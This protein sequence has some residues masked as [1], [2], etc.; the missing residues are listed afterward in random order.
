MLTIFK[1]FFFNW[2]N[3][4]CRLAQPQ[5]L[6]QLPTCSEEPSEE[7]TSKIKNGHTSLSN[8]NGIHHGAK[9][10]S[11]DNRRLSAPVSHKM[12]RKIQSSLSVNSDIS[13]KSKVNAVFSQKTGSSPEGKFENYAYFIWPDTKSYSPITTWSSK[14][15]WGNLLIFQTMGILVKCN[16][17]KGKPRLGRGVPAADILL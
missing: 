9:H 2:R 16:L 14:H 12:H 15:D 6:P 5:R 17:S 10:V 3:F 4:S 8:G 13:K 11:A 1:Y 7:E